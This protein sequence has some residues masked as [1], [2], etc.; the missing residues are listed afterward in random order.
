[1][2]LASFIFGFSMMN[3]PHSE[4]SPSRNLSHEKR[5]GSFQEAKGAIIEKI[6]SRGDLPYASIKRQIDLV[7]QLSEFE[8]GKFLIERSGLNGYWTHY[9]ISHPSQGRLTGLNQHQKPFHPLEYYLLNRSPTCL[10]TQQRFEIFKTQIQK[11]LRDGCSLASVPCGLMADLLDLDFSNISEF[12]L[13]GI[14]IDPETLSHAMSYASEN[15]LS[16]NCH[17]LHRDAWDLK[18]PEKFDLLVSN[19]LNIYEPDEEKVI[20]LYRQFHTS[21]KPN[22]IL[23]T[24]FL[25]PPP[26]P[27][28]KTGWDLTRVNM[29]DAVLQKIIFAD[30]LSVK[31]QVFRT[32]ET[33]KSHLQKAGFGDIEIHYDHAHIFPTVVAKKI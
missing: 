33:V 3:F 5:D 15:N 14:D 27:G 2:L 8:L 17:F 25:T 9:V 16:Q 18:L 32:E 20:E 24:S 31:W 11:H 7:E 28:Q 13:Y 30:I 23:I 29:E 1:M 21:L 12:S 19:G 26:I 10:A 22:G 6:H 4:K